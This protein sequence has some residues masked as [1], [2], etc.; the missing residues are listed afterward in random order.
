MS[1]SVIK[2]GV[3]G[4]HPRNQDKVT[5]WNLV[6]AGLNQ[7]LADNPGAE[8]LVISGLTDQGV[9][10][11]AYH[12]A[13]QNGWNCGG[14]APKAAERQRWFPMNEDGDILKIVGAKWGD[15]SEAFIQE[16]DVLLRVGAGRQALAEVELAEKAGMKVYTNLPKRTR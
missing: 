10:Q 2:V 11:A 5:I 4:Y 6:K 8:L 13:R 12:I 3:N 15:E 16:C 9:P 1:K 7:V 14:I